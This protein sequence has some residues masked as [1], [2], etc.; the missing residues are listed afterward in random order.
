[1]E[2]KYS[3]GHSLYVPDHAH[4][5]EKF[6]ICSICWLLMLAG[7]PLIIQLWSN[8]YF[9]VIL[10]LGSHSK[11]FFTKSMKSG[12]LS[13]NTSSKVNEPKVFSFPFYW[14]ILHWKF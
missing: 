14:G 6:F 4:F 3:E 7:S 11:H 1:M 10:F 12:S 2:R 8:A 9:A 5:I 13:P